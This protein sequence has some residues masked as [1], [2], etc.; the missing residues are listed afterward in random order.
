[1]DFTTCVLGIELGSTRIKGVLIDENHLPIA[2]GS[3]SW[4]NRLEKD[5]YADYAP[6]GFDCDEAI[7]YEWNESREKNLYGHFNFYF[8][9]TRETVSKSSMLL[10]MI[11]LFAVGLFGNVLWEMVAALLGL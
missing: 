4:E 8:G 9:I 3:Y 5:L 7:T 10:Y 6:E 1:M 11:L 2:S